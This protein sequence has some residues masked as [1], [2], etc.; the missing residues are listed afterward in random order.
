MEQ[1][2]RK[3]NMKKGMQLTAISGFVFAFA[4]STV[5]IIPAP[6]PNPPVFTSVP[7]PA[8]SDLGDVAAIFTDEMAP[9]DP[10]FFNQC[11]AKYR[12]LTELTKSRDEIHEGLRE[13]VK[14]DPVHYHWC[15]YGKILDLEKSLKNE[16]FVELRQKRILDTFE[17]LAPLG[18]V[19]SSEYHDSRYLRA[20]VVRYQKLSE[21]AFYRRLE[22]TPVGTSQLVKSSNPFGLWR[23]TLDTISVLEKYR[24]LAQPSDRLKE[25]AAASLMGSEAVEPKPVPQASPV[26][27]VA[28]GAQ[29]QTPEAPIAAPVVPV[30]QSPAPVIQAATPP[31]KPE[32][33]KVKPPASASKEASAGA[34]KK[35]EPKKVEPAPKADEAVS[36]ESASSEESGDLQLP[37][38]GEEASM[39]SSG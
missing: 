32:V 31:V 14:Q 18:K 22:L 33:S 36:D 3:W 11:D 28:S 20:A 4:C 19:F 13:L 21:W 1:S 39:D 17:F 15:F 23:D 29:K 9:R 35:P 27:S 5:E 25:D 38:E 7:H 37:I 26:P 6:M 2:V 30:A 10:D 8:G 16:S 34:Q 24:L 12:K